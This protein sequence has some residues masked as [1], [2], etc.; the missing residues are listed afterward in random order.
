MSEVKSKYR[1]RPQVERDLRF[2]RGRFTYF[3]TRKPILPTDSVL[4]VVYTL[5]QFLRLA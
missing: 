2:N 4:L 1:N 3:K 5:C